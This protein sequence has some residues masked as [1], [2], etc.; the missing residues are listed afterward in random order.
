[1][2]SGRL[3]KHDRSDIVG[4][5]MENM[6]KQTPIS[7]ERID[8]AITELYGNYDRVSEEM[9]EFLNK[10]LK[11]DDLET[12]YYETAEIEAD[13]KDK[14]LSICLCIIRLQSPLG[15]VYLDIHRYNI[16]RYTGKRKRKN[17]IFTK[18]V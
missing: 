1:M 14:L 7:K 12:L 17:V 3:Y 16:Y 2:V 11:T 10:V 6:Q 5:L 13:N 15:F 9:Q 4:V 18:I 8:T